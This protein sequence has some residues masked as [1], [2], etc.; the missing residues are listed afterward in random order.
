MNIY[1]YNTGHLLIAPYRHI[2]ALEKLPEPVLLDMLQ[3]V[4]RS[5]KAIRK[6]Y[7]PEGFNIGV[8]QGKAAGAG[9]EHHIH[10]HVVP[11]WGADT[12]FM[13]ILGETRVLPQHLEAS[14]AR[15]K[16]AFGASRPAA[17]RGRPRQR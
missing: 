15:L 4:Q 2:A 7:A 9:I 12:N 17:A 10:L 3:L 8:N 5:L 14:Y 11:R 1:P 13:P 16:A 6:A